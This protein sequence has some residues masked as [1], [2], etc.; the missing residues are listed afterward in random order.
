M[1]KCI[2]SIV[3]LLIVAL[4]SVAIS[5]HNA[6]SANAESSVLTLMVYITGSDLESNG[7]AAT[8]D[9][10]EMMRS[11]FDTEKVNIILCTGGAKTWLGRFPND[12][13][14][15]YRAAGRRPEL[16]ESFD[17][18]SMGD[19]STLS[20]F[21]N[22]SYEHFPAEQYALILWDHG[23]GPMNGVCFDEL[24]SKD[25]AHDSLDL[26]ELRT[27]LTDSPF[28]S[29]NP[30]EW[31][32]FDACL[33]SSVETAY[34]C[35]PFAKYMIASQETEPGTGWDYSF[36]E[37]ASEGLRGDEM[38]KLIV[39]SYTD[40]SHASD[41]MLTLSCID[42]L[43][44]KN[45][46][47]AMND[48][49]E[50]LDRMLS[51][52]HFSEISNGRRD[53]K[54]FGRA[55]TGSEYDLVDLFSLAEQYASV[56]T[57][58]AVALQAALENAIIV[59]A[60]N[61][62]NSH[63][64]SVYYPYYNKEYYN[65]L[66]SQQYSL[67]GFAD[68]YRSFMGHYADMWLGEQ[69]TDWSDV[70][71]IAL[72]PLPDS[73]ELTMFLNQDQIDNF[74]FAQVFIVSETPF[75]NQYFYKIDEVDDVSLADDGTLHAEYN[76]KALY[77]VDDNDKPLSDAIPYRIVDGMYLIRA[78]LS[79]KTWDMY[80]NEMFPGDLIVNK[81]ATIDVRKTYLQ[82]SLNET[83]GELSVVGIIDM[84]EDLGEG[85][86][87]MLNEGEG[88]FTGKQSL[89]IE[90]DQFNWIWFLRYPREIQYDAEGKPVPFMEWK[91][92]NT[93]G[94]IS[95]EWDDIDNTLPWKLKFCE[96]QYTGHNLFAQYIVHDTQGNLIASN[97][98]PVANPNLTDIPVENA[99][100]YNEDGLSV[101]LTGIKLATSEFDDG[102]FLH[103]DINGY[104]GQSSGDI[105]A[106]DIILNSY[107]LNNT[108]L[109]RPVVEEDGHIGYVLHIPSDHLPSQ[110]ES[111]ID[112]IGFMLSFKDSN[113]DETRNIS[114]QI[115]QNIDL[116]K[117]HAQS[118]ES[119]NIATAVKDDVTYT[120]TRINE[121]ENGDIV[122][123][124][125]VSNKSDSPANCNWL[126]SVAINGYEWKGSLS[127][128]HA[129]LGSGLWTVQEVIISP[130]SM[131]KDSA[132]NRQEFPQY[133]FLQRWSIDEVSSIELVNTDRKNVYLALEQ[134]YTISNHSGQD[135][136]V[137]G[138]IDDEIT[139]L[140][141]DEL[142]IGIR[143]FIEREDSVM[144]I[145]D[146]ANM[147]KD[148]IELYAK[149][150]WLNESKCSFGIGEWDESGTNT[151]KSLAVRAGTHIDIIWRIFTDELDRDEQI[152]SIS[153]SVEYQVLSD[154]EKRFSTPAVIRFI[155]PQ[156][157]GEIK[158]SNLRMDDL[159]VELSKVQYNTTI[160]P[161]SIID[162]SLN[163]I[164]RIE[165]YEDVLYIPLTEK[166][167]SAFESASVRL[168]SSETRMQ[169]IGSIWSP[170]EV[171]D[172][173]I[174]CTFSG[175]LIKMDQATN[176]MAQHI[177]PVD[178]GYK[179]DLR[180]ISI[181]TDDRIELSA[182]VD[183]LIVHLDSTTNR[184]II[185][186][187]VLSRN[188][189]VAENVIGQEY[190]SIVYE[191]A[192][193]KGTDLE[194]AD[195]LEGESG[196]LEDGIMHLIF[197]PAAELNPF[198]VFSI[199]NKDGSTYTIGRD[200][201]ECVASKK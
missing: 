117:I 121:N 144:M 166:Q 118:S 42:L 56:E 125:L 74:A 196:K 164:E 89:T 29:E 53:A 38:G 143:D 87:G 18:A 79:D 188:I 146:V 71:A 102:L 47:A 40:D 5:I 95:L 48:L 124:L 119:A 159:A 3:V 126:S 107:L 54:S 62:E 35:A 66:W 116:S 193:G 8:G 180:N 81:D 138:S 96:Q 192:D 158:W 63:G 162:L 154:S 152:Q 90:S 77:V 46:E 75:A 43:Q 187:V 201:N 156:T 73:Q 101:S 26:S 130:L 197:Q 25:N 67:W 189:G 115:R 65:A 21:L 61:Q 88:L 33:M 139:I 58:R 59:H 183:E 55:S 168:L 31:I 103:F 1:K 122:L 45:V 99:A 120:I 136:A 16:L 177:T 15:F 6:D 145:L 147:T 10:T 82:C 104:E 155:E 157:F 19:P 84:R 190:M 195:T 70:K 171:N 128:Q 49:F 160:E 186:S 169:Y 109:L 20:S 60:G 80:W 200:Y 69:L 39:K 173:G 140:D 57:D 13:I 184:A 68:G 93:G 64:L 133:S 44:L 50:N 110:L 91:D 179:Y 198:V 105:E 111:N 11:G 112:T 83:T 72:P 134:P 76:Y 194:R 167:M 12:K 182:S 34:I 24:F 163:G 108:C 32:G 161:S 170:I 127:S 132:F 185:E 135:L 4:A 27:A 123:E 151:Y 78:N 22:Y 149:D 165:D 97:L 141:S 51:P 100:L 37:Q 36:L 28:S 86:N 23:G 172:Q 176:P 137:V 85:P 114:A 2:R 106:H 41:L 150:T 30:L 181:S 7:G 131:M 174:C 17:L 94:R 129:T 199:T 52:E 148:T 178:D 175:L 153:L 191:Y 142:Y 9:I 14:C 92:P 98:I 113:G